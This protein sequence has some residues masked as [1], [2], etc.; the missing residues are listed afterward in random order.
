[1]SVKHVAI[2]SPSDKSIKFLYKHY[3]LKNPIA[4]MNKFVIFDEFFNGRPI[5]ERRLL[6][7]RRRNNSGLRTQ[8]TNSNASLPPPT[9]LIPLDYYPKINQ[10]KDHIRP[11]LVKT[12]E[13]LRVPDTL[14]QPQLQQKPNSATKLQTITKD[15]PRVVLEQQTQNNFNNYDP[16]PSLSQKPKKNNFDEEL[17]ELKAKIAQNKNI[18]LPPSTINKYAPFP[19][20]NNYHM[21]GVHRYGDLNG[22]TEKYRKTRLW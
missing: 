17:Y 9:H 20:L 5:D 19:S 8:S 12:V 22:F 11:V 18:P 14:S 1:M 13:A 4:Q 10:D 3:G 21:K 15:A 16:F 2:D 6:N 7:N